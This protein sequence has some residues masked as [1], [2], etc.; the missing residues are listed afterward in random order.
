MVLRFV[1]FSPPA[2]YLVVHWV[3][4]RLEI[5][6]D[7]NYLR[8]DNAFENTLENASEN[9]VHAIVTCAGTSVGSSSALKSILAYVL[10]PISMKLS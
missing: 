1:I 8:F 9:N 6:F 10:A 2:C 7:R 5:V 3:I 4:T